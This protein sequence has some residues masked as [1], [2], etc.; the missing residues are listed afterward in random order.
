MR[1]H[2]NR[3]AEKL[4][5]RAAYLVLIVISL[6]IAVAFGTPGAAF[7]ATA[8]RVS[9]GPPPVPAPVPPGGFSGVIT[10]VT[11]GPGGGTIGRL[12]VD[13]VDF[14][15][16]IPAGAFRTLVQITVTGADSTV[17]PAPAGFNVVVAVGI[18]V[19]LNGSP[20]PGTFPKALTAAF[21]ST[22][23]TASSDVM[24]WNGTSFATDPD[25]T[26]AAGVATVSFDT[27]PDFAVASRVSSKPTPIPGA[28]T[29]VTGK[30][31]LGE[32]ILAVVL[33]LAGTGGV[34]VSR[35][36]RVRDLAAEQ[37]DPGAP[38]RACRNSRLT[39]EYLYAA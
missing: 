34:A 39:A 38:T 13:D 1:A 36:R 18:E 20:Y 21:R 24:V 12:A 17:I 23:I 4:L 37:E 33:V 35:R 32:G 27:D 31:L 9:Y 6:G 7:A 2:R 8:S 26:A 28:T 16:S 5:L 30:P 25:S 14:F 3:C 15:I 29:P 10:T 22:R 11:I 19:T